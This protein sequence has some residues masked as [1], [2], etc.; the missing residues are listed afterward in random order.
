MTF[1]KDTSMDNLG[2]AEK[3]VSEVHL[4]G[5]DVLQGSHEEPSF[6]VT[7]LSKLAEFCYNHH[8]SVL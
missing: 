7:D 8:V 5:G 2:K 3:N 4:N 6:F 1:F